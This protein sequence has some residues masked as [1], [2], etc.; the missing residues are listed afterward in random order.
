MPLPGGLMDPSAIIAGGAAGGLWGW[1][2]L[3][4]MALAASS[5]ILAFTYIWGTMF[6]NPQLTAYVKSELYELALTAILIPI[7]FLAIGAMSDL[8]LGSFM[9]NELI[10][11]DA[12]PATTIYDAAAKYYERVGNDMAGW[13]QLN[14]L[15]NIYIDQMASVTPYARPLGVG[16]V[17]SPLAGLASP[18]KQLIYNM[19]VALSIAFIINHAQLV[20][21]VFSIMAF[22]KYYLPAG[23]FFRAFTPTRRLGGTLIGVSVAFLFVFP[24]ISSITYTMFYNRCDPGSGCGPLVTFRS[25]ISQFATDTAQGGLLNMMD[26]FYSHNF[27]GGI[28]DIVGGLFSGIG[29]IFQSVIG[30]L[31]LILMMIPVSIISWAFAI[32]FI[33]PAFNVLLFTQVAKGLSKSFGDEVDISSLTRMI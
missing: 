31:F 2:A 13:L 4:G 14:Y 19:S 9:P 6:R 11:D 16:L 26:N 15:L 23:I 8:R 12:S 10:P 25:M 7:L 20:V 1:A 5:T 21:Y 27:T 3:A 18:I 17:A 30:S 22:L 28:A 33:V 29:N 24:A 32:G